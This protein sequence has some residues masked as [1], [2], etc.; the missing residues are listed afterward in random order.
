MAS[1]ASVGSFD[2]S[3]I[4]M[5]M[6][7]KLAKEGG[8]EDYDPHKKIK[9]GGMAVEAKVE[10]IDDVDEDHLLALAEEKEADLP[11]DMALD[12]ILQMVDEAPE[13]A[14]LDETQLRAMINRME[15]N[16]NANVQMRIK[17][18]SKPEKFM[19][20]E[21]ALDEAIQGLQPLAAA[22]E[23]YGVFIKANGMQ[24]LLS[25]IPHENTDIG[26][27]VINVLHDIFDVEN[28]MEDEESFTAVEAFFEE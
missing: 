5:N 10:E 12:D 9:P 6:K 20:S 4:A 24:S 18:P 8:G 1:S 16:T 26:I 14:E 3:Q 23:L 27:S 7:R 28:I 25:L 21:V 2:V 17:Y 11:D 13:V 19:D 15:K 22:P